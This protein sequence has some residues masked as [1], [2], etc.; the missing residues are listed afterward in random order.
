MSGRID[1]ASWGHG[2][3]KA[4]TWHKSSFDTSWHCNHN[5]NGRPLDDHAGYYLTY[6]DATV[7][8]SHESAVQMD[9]WLD[10]LAS[11][12]KHLREYPDDVRT[13][14]SGWPRANFG[15]D[16]LAFARSVVFK[17]GKRR[18]YSVNEQK[19]SASDSKRHDK[20]WEEV[21][22]WADGGL[23]ACYRML[24]ATYASSL[25]RYAVAALIKDYFNEESVLYHV[26]DVLSTCGVLTKNDLGE[27]IDVKGRE[28]FLYAD[29]YRAVDYFVQAHRMHEAAVRSLDC[30]ENNYGKNY[31]G[32]LAEQAAA[33]AA[34]AVTV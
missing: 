25:E 3:A 34:E 15:R 7:Q 11:L 32:R 12:A 24:V 9:Q 19:I 6:G 4:Y 14:E 26:S 10:Y 22:E 27:A 28:A 20:R 30:L 31:I 33:E 8:H 16:K 18:W 17:E 23:V 21:P 29:V 5:G 2:E 13:I 1:F